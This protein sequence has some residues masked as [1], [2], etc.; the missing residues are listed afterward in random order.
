MSKKPRVFRREVKVATVKRML[1]GEDI[2][3]LAREL[4]I[5]RPILY[6]WKETYRK[7]GTAAFR[8]RRG[9]PPK[10]APTAEVPTKAALDL[11]SAKRRIAELERKIGQ[12]ELELDF[13]QRALRQIGEERRPN[14]ASGTKP[15]TSSSKR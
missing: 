7:S 3:A 6:R 4:K 1:A 5:R 12:Q 2:S 10:V 13:F 8:C 9:R 15:S 11:A 14:G